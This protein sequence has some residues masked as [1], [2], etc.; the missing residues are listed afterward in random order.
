LADYLGRQP[1]SAKDFRVTTDY[2]GDGYSAHYGPV[3]AAIALAARLEGI[4]LDP[5]YTGKALAGLL[6]LAKG[7]LEGK[8]VLF[9]HTGGFPTLFAWSELA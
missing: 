8:R 1:L 3:F 9:W 7:E 6:D 2:V 5:V 4:F